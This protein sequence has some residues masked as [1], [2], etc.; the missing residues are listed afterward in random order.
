M[1]TAL[2]RS[3]RGSQGADSKGTA[4]IIIPSSLGKL[5]NLEGLLLHGNRLTGE[6]PPS[7]GNISV[8]N[9]LDLS[10]NHLEG[11]IPSTLGQCKHLLK[12]ILFKNNLNGS[13]PKQVLTGLSSLSIVKLDV[14]MNSLTGPLPLEVGNLKNLWYLDVSQN[15]FNGEIPITL[16]SCMSLKFLYLDHNFFEREIPMN[17][18]ALEG[19]SELDL[20]R[21]NLSGSIPKYLQSFP[22][23][24]LNLSLN[25]LE[26]EVPNGGIFRNSS[27]VFVGGNKKLCGGI[28][29]LHLPKCNTKRSMKRE[30]SFHLKILIAIIFSAVGCFFLFLLVWTSCPMMRR[31]KKTLS[32]AC[33][34]DEFNMIKLSYEDLFKATNGFSETNLI[35]SGS[36][37]CV[38]KGVLGQDE[39]IV[40]VKVLNLQQRGAPKS[41]KVECNALRNIR[42]RN[43]VKILTSCS[44]IDSKGDD[45]KALVYEFMPNGSLEQWLHPRFDGEHSQSRTLSLVQRITILVDVASALEYLHHYCHARIVHCDLKPNIWSSWDKIMRMRN[46]ASTII[47]LPILIKDPVIS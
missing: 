29:E 43:L 33:S 7:L 21:N 39:T 42:H 24:Y 14:F 10:Y 40:T 3:R 1:A 30:R 23:E 16:G 47:Q 20:S 17:L 22:L 19:L 26:G 2:A 6:I 45:F 8:L 5:Q 28:I 4:Q 37:G 38:Y 44:S 27:V 11:P 9:V 12:L 34:T 32:S 25:N 35:G 18:K 13:I 41:F 15:K 31:A 36:F 46:E